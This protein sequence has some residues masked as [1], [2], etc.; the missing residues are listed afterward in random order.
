MDALA[1][2]KEA[3]GD[4]APSAQRVLE[5]TQAREGGAACRE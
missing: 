4:F 5:Q 1:S 3:A 2:I